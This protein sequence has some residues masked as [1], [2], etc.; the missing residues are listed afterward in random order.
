[1]KTPQQY[2]AA[3]VER[4]MKLQDVLLKAMAG[5]ITWWAAA[6]IIGVSVAFDPTI[7]GLRDVGSDCCGSPCLTSSGKTASINLQIRGRE[8][9]APAA[10]T[11]QPE[12]VCPNLD[13]T[14]TG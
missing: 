9:K 14:R 4:M 7:G 10:R 1:V 13:I 5:K 12:P 8:V 11:C 6:E 3:E 2:P